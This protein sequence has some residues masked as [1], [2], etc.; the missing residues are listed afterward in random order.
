MFFF[1]GV[2]F[3]L[4]VLVVVSLT[5]RDF[6]FSGVSDSSSLE[7][8]RLP[9]KDLIFFVFVFTGALIYLRANSTQALFGSGDF[10]K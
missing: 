9:K 4:V 7:G 5:L 8:A 3:V 1:V 6:F 10:I 2:V